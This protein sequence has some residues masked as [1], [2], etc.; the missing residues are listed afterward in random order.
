MTEKPGVSHPR[1]SMVREPLSLPPWDIYEKMK[2]VK[3]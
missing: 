3:L 1:D 2:W